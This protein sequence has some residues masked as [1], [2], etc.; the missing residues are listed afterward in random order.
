MKK[1][2][3]WLVLCIFGLSSV[4]FGIAQT[5]PGADNPFTPGGAGCKSAVARNATGCR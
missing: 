3:K 5:S 1:A 2:V 4:G